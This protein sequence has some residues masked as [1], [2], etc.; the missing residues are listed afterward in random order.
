MEGGRDEDVG[1]DN[2]LLEL[3]LGSLLVVGDNEPGCQLV[4]GCWRRVGWCSASPKPPPSPA[5]NSLVALLL[6]PSRDA[7]LVLNG[8][9]KT[10]L[11]ASS[12]TARVEDNKNLDHG[13]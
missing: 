13:D 1:V 10:G 2:V 5:L 3:G 4:L 9:E 12:V 7:E 11:L 8:A 6:E